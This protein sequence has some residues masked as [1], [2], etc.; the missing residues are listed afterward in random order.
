MLAPGRFAVI[1]VHPSRWPRVGASLRMSQGGTGTA[2]LDSRLSGRKSR[3]IAISR[4]K[5]DL[6]KLNV[7]HF[8]TIS[9]TSRYRL[10]MTSHCIVLSVFATIERLQLLLLLWLKRRRNRRYCVHPIFQLR[11]TFGEYHHLMQQFLSDDEKC[12]AYIRMRP[13]TFKT[14]LEMIGPHI[15]KRTTNF[16]KPLP[17]TERLVI[18]LR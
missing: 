10:Q 13:D 2:R 4:G 16:R 9:F 3:V 7:S 18:T 11:E 5:R 15:E 1:G 17:A 8:I 14:L 6:S 12:L